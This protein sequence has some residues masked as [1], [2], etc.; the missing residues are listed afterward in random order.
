MLSIRNWESLT[1]ERGWSVDHYVDR[2][3]DLTKRVFVRVSDEP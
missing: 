1:R 2:M 3:R